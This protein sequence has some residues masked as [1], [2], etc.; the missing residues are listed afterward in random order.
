MRAVRGV[1]RKTEATNEGEDSLERTFV[2][3]V[4]VAIRRGRRAR[5]WTQIELA[6][7][8][9][10]SSNYIAR[11]ERGELGPSLWVAHRIA[12]ALGVALDALLT[13]RPSPPALTRGSR[14][15]GSRR[16]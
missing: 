16:S 10:L 11:L 5:G 1:R 15:K 7:Q 8:A 12:R 2:Q 3:S 13:S 6:Q 14:V 4:G 9:R